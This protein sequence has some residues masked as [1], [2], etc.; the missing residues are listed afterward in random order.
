[1]QIFKFHENVF[2]TEVMQTNFIKN[3]I[4][5]EDYE[6]IDINKLKSLIIHGL[7]P[8][9]Q[10]TYCRYLRFRESIKSSQL[11]KS[12][13]EN[14][15]FFFLDHH[16]FDV[17]NSLVRKSKID[18]ELDLFVFKTENYYLLQNFLDLNL[19]SNTILI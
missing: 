9:K 3:G 19:I 7:F 5:S 13:A 2:I 12:E 18:S 15:I 6:T 10:R 14:R 16:K 11:T 8:L 1:M 4:L 17:N